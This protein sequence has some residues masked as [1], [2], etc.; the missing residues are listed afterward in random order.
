MGAVGEMPKFLWWAKDSGIGVPRAEFDHIVDKYRQV[1]GARQDPHNG[2][3]LG[4]V[5]CKKAV[6]AHGGRI[7]L[8][9]ESD[10]GSIFL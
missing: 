4:L 7:W 1:M 9:S 8:E 5:I 10:E 3:G 6:E 2:S